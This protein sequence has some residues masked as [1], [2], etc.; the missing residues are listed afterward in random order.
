MKKQAAE[1]TPSSTKRRRQRMVQYLVLLV[2]CVVVIDA[3][4][5]DKGLIAMIK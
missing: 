1:P 5:G 3:L 4:V 2:G